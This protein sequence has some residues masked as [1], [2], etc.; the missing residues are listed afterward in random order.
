MSF[1]IEL[2][3]ESENALALKLKEEV[4]EKLFTSKNTENFKENLL[5]ILS[6]NVDQD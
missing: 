4:I 6:E 5:Q 3:Q 1:C 2:E